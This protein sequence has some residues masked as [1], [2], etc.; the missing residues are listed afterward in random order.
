MRCSRWC[1]AIAEVESSDNGYGGMCFTVILIW[2]GGSTG[3]SLMR[4]VRRFVPKFL[5]Y[6]TAEA[7]ENGEPVD[8][9]VFRHHGPTLATVVPSPNDPGISWRQPSRNHA[10]TYDKIVNVPKIPSNMAKRT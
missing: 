5:G 8:I 7:D 3:S 6:H 4:Q 2:M 9:S 10:I 1:T